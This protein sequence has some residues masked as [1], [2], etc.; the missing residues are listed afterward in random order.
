MAIDSSAI[1]CEDCLLIEAQIARLQLTRIAHAFARIVLAE[2]YILRHP[3]RV[4]SAQ[5]DTEGS[6]C[7]AQY[8]IRR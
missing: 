4:P 5:H 7:R 2:Q 1:G 6:D 3:Q 8:R